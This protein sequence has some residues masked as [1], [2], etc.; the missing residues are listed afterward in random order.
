MRLDHFQQA[1][2]W[3]LGGTVQNNQSSSGRPAQGVRSSKAPDQIGGRF[4]M[5][6]GENG[7][8]EFESTHGQTLADSLLCIRQFENHARDG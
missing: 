3:L 1:A 8:G 6:A 7:G 2:R 4:D 5:K